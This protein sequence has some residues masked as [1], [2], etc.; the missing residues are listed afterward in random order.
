MRMNNAALL[1]LGFLSASFWL[2]D[3]ARCQT[4]LAPPLSL[5][6]PA[7]APDDSGPPPIIRASPNED[8]PP[9]ATAKR[10][11][12]R[13]TARGKPQP[14]ASNRASPPIETD[15]TPTATAKRPAAPVAASDIPTPKPAADYD[16]FITAVQEEADRKPSTKPRAANRPKPAKEPVSVAKQQGLDYGDDDQLKHKLTI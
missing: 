2:L 16:G 4:S 7:P 9:A 10:S 12:P 1:V 5:A 6:R 8:D 15:D 13:V 14:A 11:A 3:S